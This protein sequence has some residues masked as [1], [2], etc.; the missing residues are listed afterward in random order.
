MSIT[1]THIINRDLVDSTSSSWPITWRG[2]DSSSFD[3]IE[4]EHA[5]SAGQTTVYERSRRPSLSRSSTYTQASTSGTYFACLR[6]LLSPSNSPLPFSP[7]FALGHAFRRPSSV[8]TSRT[9]LGARILG[10]DG[11]VRSHRSRQSVR[12]SWEAVAT[13]RWCLLQDRLP[14]PFLL[15][16]SPSVIDFVVEISPRSFNT[17]SDPEYCF[18]EPFFTKS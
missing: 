11:V 12:E 18:L 1:H 15:H 7:R 2:V 13:A 6:C 14:W 16:H 9:S 8:T 10:P 5:S 4:A 17:R 3:F